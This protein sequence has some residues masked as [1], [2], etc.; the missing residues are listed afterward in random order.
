M[1]EKALSNVVAERGYIVAVCFKS[2][3][4]GGQ[5]GADYQTVTK[6]VMLDTLK[7]AIDNSTN[8][9]VWLSVPDELSRR[10]FRYGVIDNKLCLVETCLFTLG[11]IKEFSPLE[12]RAASWRTHPQPV[13]A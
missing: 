5:N 7:E 4:A 1:D 13:A 11:V 10:Q 3:L 6:S 12:M 9:S 8:E 2:G